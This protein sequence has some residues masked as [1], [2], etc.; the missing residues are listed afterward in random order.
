MKTTKDQFE[1]FQAEAEKWINTLGISDFKVHFVHN[2]ECPGAAGWCSGDWANG[3]CT[4]GL[5]K[6]WQGK[7]TDEHVRA[8]ARHEVLELLVWPLF[9]VAL[10][11]FTTEEMVHIARHKVIRT[12]ENL[13]NN[14]ESE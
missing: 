13:F 6:T 7:V 8:T 1:M 3:V 10:S 4:I 5:T 9:D 14:F 2:D 12:L 11:R